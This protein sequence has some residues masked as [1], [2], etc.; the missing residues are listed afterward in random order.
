MQTLTRHDNVLCSR[1]GT[2]EWRTTTTGGDILNTVDNTPGIIMV[3]T[4]L[5]NL[6]P[7]LLEKRT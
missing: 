3:V 6:N 4:S 5:D 2:I 7:V 1:I